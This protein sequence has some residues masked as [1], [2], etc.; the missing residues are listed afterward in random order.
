[1]SN[2]LRD[3]FVGIQFDDGASKA[4]DR[5][6]DKMDELE[7][8]FIKFGTK[9]DK[10]GQGLKTMGSAGIKTTNNISNGF[11]KSENKVTGFVNKVDASKYSL[12]NVG[13]EGERTSRKIKSGMDSGAQSVEKLNRN[14]KDAGGGFGRLKETVMG[15]GTAL[16]IVGLVNKGIGMVK[17]SLD[18]AINR[19][20]TLAGFPV[21]MEKMGFSAELA[22]SSINKLSEGIQGLPTTLD[23][24]VGSTQTLSLMTG[25]LD[26]ATDTA[27]ALNNAFI[28]SGSD[29]NDAARGLD[30][31]TKMLSKNKVESDSWSTLQETMGYALNKTAESFGFAGKSA[32]N[33]LYTA[34][35]KGKLSFDDFNKRIIELSG[36]VGG[37]A[38]IAKD[39][40]AG[41]G[42]SFSNMK[43]AVT[44]GTA[45]IIQSVQGL[46]A[47]TS[48]GSIENVIGMIGKNFN[49]G[50][51]YISDGIKSIDGER[52]GAQLTSGFKAVKSVAIPTFGIIKDG[53]GWFNNNKEITIAG[54]SGIAAGFA[55]LKV[56]SIVNGL[57]RAYQASAFASTVA[58]HGLNAA[59][60][61]NPIGLVVTGIGLLVAGG[62][63][64]YRNFDTVKTK[65]IEL[66]GKLNENPFTSFLLNLN[67]VIVA[68][69][70]L[71]Q[72]FDKIK[73]SFNNFKNAITNFEV[74][75]WVS[76][77]GGAISGAASKVAGMVNG[78]HA[79]GLENVPFDGYRA[80]LHKGES[81]LTAS[82]S[83]YLRDAGI[84]TAN[85]DGTPSINPISPSIP[86]PPFS[87]T[88]PSTGVLS[89][90][91]DDSKQ[92]HSLGGLIGKA[93]PL[94]EPVD[95]DDSV[96]SS[97]INNDHTKNIQVSVPIELV[98]Q[99]NADDSSIQKLMAMLPAEVKRVIEEI[100]REKLAT[101]GG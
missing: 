32:Q 14:V 51:G 41:I 20:D 56:I 80:E 62:V 82:Q 98:I 36:G 24:I 85:S 86:S 12:K 93:M 92:N 74:P 66:W 46:L 83:A 44:R 34:L 45:G 35:K 4:I 65:T 75:G 30:Q 15:V 55:S 18:N 28:A 60:R 71:Y 52:L 47:D 96:G 39:G 10:S 6:D 11:N 43:T 16:G 69:K 64:L 48:F 57:M 8:G 67:P 40:S 72:N 3:M 78:S 33:D 22:E 95:N 91:S 54:L 1:M 94:N 63:A 77:I 53:I 49:K 73:S 101:R 42:T 9:V 58:T 76:S 21:I 84:L 81:V 19:V 59:L 79:T 26:K 29:S 25:D 100:F 61:A 70:I 37:F 27:L 97:T 90:N 31:Y 50:L 2:S 99:G 89:G 13:S 17:S 7:R 68:G 88:F 5:I 23:G 38:E 87:E